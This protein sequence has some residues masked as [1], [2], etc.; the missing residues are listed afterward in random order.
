MTL[1]FSLQATVESFMSHALG[2]FTRECEADD[3]L[4]NVRRRACYKAFL[5]FGVP[6]SAECVPVIRMASETPNTKELGGYLTSDLLSFY[7]LVTGI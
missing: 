2:Q 6:D 5:S 4:G 7:L 1:P 3:S